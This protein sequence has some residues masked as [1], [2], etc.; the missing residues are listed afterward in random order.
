M[1]STHTEA[2]PQTTA[3]SVPTT[4]LFDRTD[5]TFFEPAPSRTADHCI[6]FWSY[7]AIPDE[8]VSQ[9]VSTYYQTRLNEVQQQLDEQTSTW[10][11]QWIDANPKP[12]KAS[13]EAEWNA[14]FAADRQAFMDP[15]REELQ[16]ERPMK[17]VGYDAPQLVRAAQMFVHTPNWEKFTAEEHYKVRQHPIELYDEVLTVDE[18]EER[19]S[20]YRM[21][22]ALDKIFE[23][24]SQKDIFTELRFLNRNIEVIRDEIIEWRR[25][26]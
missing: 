2:A 9:L 17:L 26:R 25:E 5:G 11:Q 6:G 21:H 1:T 18:I 23:E 16:N 10:A 19:Y 7:V 14:R 4:T 8:I 12:K 22:S 3:D 20:L 13:Q 15:L 24:T